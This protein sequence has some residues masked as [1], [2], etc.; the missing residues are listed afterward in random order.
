[1]RY[2][3]QSKPNLFW[4]ALFCFNSVSYN[5]FIVVFPANYLFTEQL[6]RVCSINNWKTCLKQLLNSS[7]SNARGYFQTD[8]LH[9][10]ICG[11][12]EEHQLFHLIL[13]DHKLVCFQPQNVNNLFSAVFIGLLSAKSCFS[14]NQHSLQELL[15]LTVSKRITQIQNVKGNISVG[16]CLAALWLGEKSHV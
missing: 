7:R 11:E 1:M 2:H 4:I 9:F 5:T 8:V 15:H 10:F 16:A 14:R 12:R 13:S 6:P 3:Q